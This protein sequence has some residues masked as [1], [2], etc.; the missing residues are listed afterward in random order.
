M[1]RNFAHPWQLST[2]E[3]APF[4]ILRPAG[5]PVAARTPTPGSDKSMKTV[6]AF[7]HSGRTYPDAFVAAARLNRVD[8]RA[9]EDA[10]V[11]D[12][13][14]FDDGLGAR[15]DIWAIRA[16]YARA[17]VDVNRHPRELDPRLIRGALPKG[18]LSE[19][20]KVRNG[21]GVVPRCLTP[22]AEI[23]RQPI[24]LSDVTGR[25]STLHQPYHEQLQAL[26]YEARQGRSGAD[27]PRVALIDWHS[28]PSSALKSLSAL[29]KGADIVLGDLYGESCTAGLLDA[30]RRAFEA[31]GFKVSLNMPFAGGYTTQVYGKPDQGVEALQIEINRGLYMNEK[32]IEPGVGF[33]KVKQAVRRAA[34][35]F[36]AA[37]A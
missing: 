33:E 34:M 37:L 28:M 26:I 17:F 29:G 31:E 35:R 8:L 20:Q 13:V 1:T 22:E 24:T 11:D 4:D 15:E 21:F 6:F 30:V 27:G 19:T 18:S 9:T 2:I 12:L 3:A 32:T 14:G 10:F 5:M 23:Y 16:N 7:P 36:R 25:I